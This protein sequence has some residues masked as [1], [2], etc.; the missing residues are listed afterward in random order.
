MPIPFLDLFYQ[1]LSMIATHIANQMAQ[2]S[3]L[4]QF[5]YEKMSHSRKFRLGQYI[6]R[7]LY[8]PPL[9][10]LNLWFLSLAI[11]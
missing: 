4:A 3:T 6:L 7:M 1:L 8:E 2:K 9:R 5:T 11:S 10:A